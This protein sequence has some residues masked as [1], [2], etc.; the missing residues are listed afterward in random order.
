MS[1]IHDVDQGTEDWYKLRAGR[2]TASEFS[3]IVTSDG[4]ESKSRHGYAV[5]LAGEMYAG[6]PL[7]AWEGNQWSERGRGTEQEA[8]DAYAFLTGNEVDIVGFATDDDEQ[9]GCSPD[10]LVGDNG[11]VEFKVLKPERH[12]E[13]MLYYKK[14]GYCPP[15][16]IQQ[17]QGQMLVTGRRWVDLVF[18]HSILPTVIIRQEPILSVVSGLVSGL[19]EVI[20]E[21][22]DIVAE[23][24]SYR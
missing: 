10:G 14:H 3:K 1:K 16:Y 21:R 2:P 24:R 12:I 4:K 9:Y 7:E 23:L 15:D 6:R 20:R 18:Y 19:R 17:T 22:D 5:T 11:L 13:A 8:S